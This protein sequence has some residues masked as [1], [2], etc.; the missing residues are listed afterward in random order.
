M[1]VLQNNDYIEMECPKCK[2]D[3]AV[4]AK[5]IRCPELHGGPSVICCVCSRVIPMRFSD[6]PKRWMPIVYPYD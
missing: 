1:R 4:F 6:I 3:L 2:S 5:D